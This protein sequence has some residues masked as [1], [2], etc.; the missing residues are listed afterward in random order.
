MFAIPCAT[1]STF[2]LCLSP[3]IRSATTADM[4]DSMAP[5]IATVNAGIRSG[6]TLSIWNSGT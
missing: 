3:L 5:S 2:G 6:D 4:S 1:S